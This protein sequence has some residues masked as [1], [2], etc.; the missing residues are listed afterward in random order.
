VGCFLALH[1]MRLGPKKTVKPLVDLQSSTQL[2]H[3]ASVNI[4]NRVDDDFF[5]R[6][7]MVAVSLT[8]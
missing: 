7:P 3:S 4:L 6:S 2:A 5:R 1:N 8:N